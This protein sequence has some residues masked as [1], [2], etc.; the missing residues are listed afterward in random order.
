MQVHLHYILVQ[1]TQKRWLL[2]TGDPLIKV[3]TYAGL[4]ELI[5]GK[6]ETGI[7]ISMLLHT[8]RNN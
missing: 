2:K 1:G 5:M 4:T 8:E 6:V 7:F 3:T